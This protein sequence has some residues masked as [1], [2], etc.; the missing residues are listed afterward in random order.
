[1]D[2]DNPADRPL[3]RRLATLTGLA[4]GF[5]TSGAVSWATPD[6]NLVAT[7]VPGLAV[8]LLVFAA[9]RWRARRARPGSH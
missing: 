4:A 3:S 5:I 8:G 7:L 1:M 2:I 9:M 6:G